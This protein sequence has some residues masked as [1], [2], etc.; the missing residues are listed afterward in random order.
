[1][2]RSV[3]TIPAKPRRPT[4]EPRSGAISTAFS[5]A[6]ESQSEPTNPRRQEQD[7]EQARR[8]VGCGD[9]SRIPPFGRRG[10][11]RVDGRGRRCRTKDVTQQYQRSE[12]QQR[13]PESLVVSRAC[14]PVP[15]RLRLPC[16]MRGRR[17]HGLSLRWRH[18]RAG[19]LSVGLP[20][21]P[22][23]WRR[24]LVWIGRLPRRRS[25]SRGWLRPARWRPKAPSRC[26]RRARPVGIHPCPVLSVNPKI[27][28]RSS[29]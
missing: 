19:M 28:K 11:I 6:R 29:L 22:T 5:R 23:R 14:R 4:G 10:L 1:V 20:E 8:V 25:P 18:I 3:P 15:D 9:L 21:L 7:V 24:R 17:V 16:A 27:G 26:H 2:R 13:C 12:H